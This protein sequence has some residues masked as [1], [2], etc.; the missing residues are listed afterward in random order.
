[1]TS[2]REM[3]G[4]YWRAA[5][6][7]LRNRREKTPIDS[8][9][10][11]EGFV[12]SRAAYIAQKTLFSYV[13]TR[14]GIRYPAMFANDQIIKSLDIAKMHVF[15]GCLSD[16]TIYGVAVGLHGQP[17]GDADREKLALHCY[18]AAL[19]ENA[20]SAPREFSAQDCIEEF[21]QRLVGADWSNGARQPENFTESPRAL[22][23]WAPIAVELKRFDEEIVE[24][25]IKY[26]WRDIREQFQMR[27]NSD[28]VYAD[29]ARQSAPV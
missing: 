11:L 1:M 7:L 22:Y 10:A 24:N 3:A 6:G 2:F 9:A 19:S 15:A 13:K 16:F 26:A 20:G 4:H 21:K 8:V 12:A 23:R 28:A 27:I 5:S 17:L 18:E 25:S 29:W 14:M